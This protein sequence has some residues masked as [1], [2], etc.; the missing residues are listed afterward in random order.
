[1]LSL[2]KL[3]LG[4]IFIGIPLAF[5]LITGCAAVTGHSKSVESF[6]KQLISGNCDLSKFNKKIQERDDLVFNGVQA[7]SIARQCDDYHK[8][9]EYFDKVESTYKEE[10][11]KDN[12][13]NN[14]IESIKSVLVNNNTNDYEGNTYEKIMINTYKALNYMALNDQ[15]NA[16]IEFNRALDR[17]RRAKDFYASEIAEKQEDNGKPYSKVTKIDKTNTVINQNFPGLFDGFQAYPDFVN[18]FTTYMSG[19]FFMINGDPAKARDLL[20]ESSAMLPGNKQVKADFDLSNQMLNKGGKTNKKY[21]WVIYENGQ[22]MVKE[23]LRIDI[24]LFLVSNK[25]LYTG[26]ALPKLKNRTSSYSYL[27]INQ[28]KT[29]VVSDMD[30][31][32]KTEFKKRLPL[33]ASEAVASAIVKTIA[34]KE[35]EKQGGLVGSLIGTAFHAITNKA[36]VRSWS[37]L[38][39][40]FQVARIEITDKP[41]SIKSDSGKEIS[42]V[43]ASKSKNAI[44]YIRSIKPGHDNVKT[45]LF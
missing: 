3:R 21:A 9:N 44:I 11:D 42:S 34:N 10:V 5:S 27:M 45:V 23:E 35:L 32:I 33:I 1:M 22:A 31:V 12:A 39:K 41:I 14:S 38:P 43:N 2:K 19:L 8:S 17:Q 30:R 40:N 36:D 37:A 29:E 18:P 24:P 28:A 26:I 6:D 16:R 20:K 7:A 15:D 13:M 25:T 4:L